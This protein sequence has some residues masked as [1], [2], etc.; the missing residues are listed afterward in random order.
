MNRRLI[1][2]LLLF[3]A[4]AFAHTQSTGQAP[5]PQQE[6]RYD[7]RYSVNVID[8]ATFYGSLTSRCQRF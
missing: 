6:S 3:A 5:V 7:D 1:P 8:D 2:A 4:A